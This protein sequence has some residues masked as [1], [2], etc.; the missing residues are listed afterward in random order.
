MCDLHDSIKAYAAKKIMHTWNMQMGKNHV[1]CKQNMQSNKVPCSRN[2]IVS[3]HMQQKDNA[4]MKHA[5][6]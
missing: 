2:M 6:G 3:K 4:Y 5:N 1:N